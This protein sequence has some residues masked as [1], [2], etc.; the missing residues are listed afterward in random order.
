MLSI[1]VSAGH[2]YNVQYRDNLATGSWLKL[3]DLPAQPAS[4]L[5]NV[6]DTNT[7]STTRFYQI[8]TP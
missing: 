7:A 5:V 3:V 4:G 6:I 1:N 8:R 2:T